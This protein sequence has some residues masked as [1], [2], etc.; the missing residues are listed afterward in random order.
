MELTDSTGAT[1]SLAL[2]TLMP[3]SWGKRP[4][5]LSGV[6]IPFTKFTGVDLTKAKSVRFVAKAGTANHDILIDLLR[7][8]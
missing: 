3:V 1:S 7:L 2:S 5:R 4:R 8:E 6:Y